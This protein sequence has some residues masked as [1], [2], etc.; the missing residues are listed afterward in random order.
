[1]VVGRWS[2]VVGC[3][4]MVVGNQLLEASRWSWPAVAV[5]YSLNRPALV[6]N[7]RRLTTND[8]RRFS[9]FPVLQC[10]PK[11]DPDVQE[12]ESGYHPAYE[13]GRRQIVQRGIGKEKRV[14][15][16][17]RPPWNDHQHD[18]DGG[19]QEDEEQHSQT[20]RPQIQG[21]SRSPGS[22]AFALG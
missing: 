15:G 9:I 2:M 1:L 14:L 12:P 4:S 17:L 3:R 21:R 6:A 22:G 10:L 20:P 8:R 18:S 5:R 19:A 13:A 7:D 16:P 11:A